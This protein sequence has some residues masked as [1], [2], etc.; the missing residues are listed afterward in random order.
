MA[1]INVISPYF[2]NLQG[3]TL[4]SATLEI[5][6]YIGAANTTWQGNPQYTLTSTVVNKN[7][8]FEVAELIK[9]YIPAEFNGTYP[10]SLFSK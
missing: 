6:I 1:K 7:I 8:N 2:I 5:E 9:D 4:L 10:N 3:T